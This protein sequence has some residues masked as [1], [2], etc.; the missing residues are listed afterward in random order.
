M[1]KVFKKSKNVSA[2]FTSYYAINNSPYLQPMSGLGSYNR[3]AGAVI[4]GGPRA[5]AGSA[6]RIYNYLTNI[7][8]LNASLSNFKN[9]LKAQSYN[10]NVSARNYSFGW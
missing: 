7:G 3:T 1:P 8:Q 2:K 10:M 5:G 4:L 9:I 6:V